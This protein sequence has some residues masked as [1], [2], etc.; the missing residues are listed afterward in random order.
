MNRAKEIIDLVEREI[1][2]HRDNG[3]WA[4]TLG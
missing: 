1:T 3:Q 4:E 2:G